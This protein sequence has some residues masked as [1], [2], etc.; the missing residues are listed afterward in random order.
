[1]LEKIICPDCKEE[2]MHDGSG[3][4]CVMMCTSCNKYFII[5][6]EYLTDFVKTDKY[7]YNVYGQHPVQADG[8][9][10]DFNF[11]FRAKWD[12]W[13]FT[14]CTSHDYIDVAS[15]LNPPEDK[16][17]DFEYNDGEKI[18]KGYWLDSR[19]GNNTDASYMD[20]KTA[21]KIIQKCILKFLNEKFKS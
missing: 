19:Y 14:I 8:Y 4:G 13:D 17:G 7:H 12:F 11:Y 6:G 5:S 20:L 9:I 10:L 18:Y 21:N 15:F 2:F 1:M 3:A 16:H